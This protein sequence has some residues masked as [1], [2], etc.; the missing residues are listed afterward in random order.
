MTSARLQ[1]IQARRAAEFLDVCADYQD[2]LAAA[3]Q[4]VV[5][6]RESGNENA[7]AKAKAALRPVADEMHAFRGWAR[8]MGSPPEGR[9]G[10]DAVIRAG[11]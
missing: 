8:T 2:R 4:K 6:A 7:V 1:A 9:P 10:R 11:V 3:K 5:E